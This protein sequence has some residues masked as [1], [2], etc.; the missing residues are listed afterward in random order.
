MLK[1]AI[2]D[3]N[4]V[5]LSHAA[6]LVEKELLSYSPDIKLFSSTD[7]FLAQIT[8]DHYAPD[9]VILD[10]EFD[11][12]SSGIDFAASLNRLLPFCRIIYLTAYPNYASDVYTTDH[13]W[14]VVKARAE[15]YL[16]Q[17]LHKAIEAGNTAPPLHGIT[18]KGRKT[19]QFLPLGEILYLSREGRKA[20]I[21]TES[22]RHYSSR[23]PASLLGGDLAGSFVRCHQ[24]YWVNLQKI[25]ALERESFILI[26]G[27]HI[28]ISRTCRN[29]ARTRYLARYHLDCL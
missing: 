27:E 21:V 24:G 28:P 12:G 20:V 6:A 17:A 14:F 11:G 25:A 26:N 19:T 10:I 15:E 16:G 5:H 9:I 8:A 29:E 13:I 22:G 7:I 18:L 23:P 4:P 3:D 1:I 2:C